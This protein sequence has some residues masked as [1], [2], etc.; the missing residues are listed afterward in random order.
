M[1]LY[2]L[3]IC[4]TGMGNAALLM[5]EMGHAVEGADE[6]AFPPMSELLREQAITVHEGYS[7]ERVAGL[8]PDLVVVGNAQTRG[9]PEVEWLLENPAQAYT[10]LPDLLGRE[11]LGQRRSV[12]VTGTHGKTTTATLTAHLLREAACEPGY[13]IGGVPKGWGLGARLGASDAPFV[14]EGDE[15]DS[16]FFDKR[17]KFIHYRPNILILNNLEFDHGD[18]F[19]DLADIQRSFNHL[20]KLVPASGWVLVNGDDANLAALDPTP[21]TRR[22]RVGT[23][24]DC[25]WQICDFQ[26]S[27]HGSRFRLV[28]RDPETA[29]RALGSAADPAP[30]EVTLPLSGMFNARNAAMA[31]LAARLAAPSPSAMLS[32]ALAGFSGV[33]RRQEILHQDARC[34]LIEDFGHHPTAIA[35]TLDSL[36]ARYPQHR[37]LAAFEPRSNTAV[38]NRFQAEFADALARAHGVLLAPIYRADK[39]P[40]DQR[41]D[42][43]ALLAHTARHGAQPPL[44]HQACRD[45]DA[46]QATALETLQRATPDA[47]VLMVAFSN[48]AFGGILPKLCTAL[49]N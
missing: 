5:R 15:Y 17:S 11:L 44:P 42:R 27:P 13:L 2:F 24:S 48:G 38:T 23:G 25:D 49:A 30:L 26:E 12:V 3:G 10:S 41:L 39:L 29:R 45:F 37:I 20:L 19:R 9:N 18:I 4:G 21:W 32:Q 6:R 1:R 46:L 36:R 7:A 16:A 35:Q 28:W 22:L 33:R 34:I 40:A 31:T 8:R 47:P 43:E 14:I